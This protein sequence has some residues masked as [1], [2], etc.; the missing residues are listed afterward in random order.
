[1]YEHMYSPA[2]R[3]PSLIS[4]PMGINPGVKRDSGVFNRV[5]FGLCDKAD[6]DFRP[7]KVPASKPP[8]GS[9]RWGGCIA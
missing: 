6:R 7:L 4:V 1:M 8:S 5:D 3:R 9:I 2:P